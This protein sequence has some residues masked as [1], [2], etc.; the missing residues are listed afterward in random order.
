MHVE[1][2]VRDSKLNKGVLLRRNMVFGYLPTTVIVN[3]M[4]SI[5]LATYKFR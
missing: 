2:S 3:S 4:I 1:G 5:Q